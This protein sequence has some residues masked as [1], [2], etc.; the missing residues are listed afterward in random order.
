MLV[1]MFHFTSVWK[2]MNIYK[3]TKNGRPVKT[4]KDFCPRNGPKRFELHLNMV[5]LYPT[6]LHMFFSYSR[7]A[8]R[9]SEKYIIITD[10]YCIVQY[11]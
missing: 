2:K 8:G 4:E 1:S 7:F 11:Y 10:M 3:K 5:I 6:K 9:H